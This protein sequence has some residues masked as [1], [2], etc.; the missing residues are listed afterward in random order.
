MKKKNIIS[1]IFLLLANILQAQIG[2][3]KDYMSYTEVQ[4]IVKGGNKLY[5]RADSSI[6]DYNL[7]DQSITTHSRAKDLNDVTIVKIRWNKVSKRL[8]I[9]YDNGNMDILESNG[10]VINMADLY[11]KENAI[12]KSIVNIIM[13]DEKAYVCTGFGVMNI[14]TKKAVINE[15]YILNKTITH[16]YVQNDVMYAKTSDNKILQVSMKSNMIDPS[17]WTDATDYKEEWFQEDTSDFD[18]YMPLVSTLKPGGPKNNNFFSLHFNRGKLYSVPG[19]YMVSYMADRPGCIQVFDGNNWQIYEDPTDNNPDLKQYY[20]ELDCITTTS[21]G[22]ERVFAGGKSGL[23]EFIDGRF[24]KH[25]T[26]NNST[27]TSPFGDNKIYVVIQGITFDSQ[28]TLWCLNSMANNNIHTLDANNNWN[29]CNVYLKENSNINLRHPFFD[30]RGLLWFVNDN[31]LSSALHCYQP[32]TGG[33]KTI[34]S[35]YNQDGSSLNINTGVHC[36][37]EDNDHNIWIGTVAGPLMLPADE[38]NSSNPVFTQVK[39]PRNDG[40]NYA[41]YLLNNIDINAMA[42]DGAG[43]LWMGTANNGVYLIDNDKMTQLQHFTTTN[44]PLLSDY[45]YDIAVNPTSGVVYISTEK[46]LCSYHSD[47]TTPNEDMD[48]DNVWAYPNPVEPHYTGLIT[49]TGLSYN[50]DVKICTANGAI[51]NQGRSNGGIYQW[52]GC[53]SKGKRVASG[54]YMVQTAKSDGSKGTVCKIAVVN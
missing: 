41:D 49:I 43:R 16:L 32:E 8:L 33:I 52:D 15:S 39:I 48:K 2:T 14:D 53:D 21:S 35:F 50:A 13:Y 26:I 10:N 4:Q 51:I 17:N 27:L 7:N 6:Y 20:Y 54:V 28:G 34:N 1:F 44:S 18:E 23:F 38:I 47:A 46:G 40:T 3:W 37:L 45:I 31:W 5:V 9:A 22:S 12:D 11:N 25:H 29:D 30:S 19:M 36:V 42:M 24:V